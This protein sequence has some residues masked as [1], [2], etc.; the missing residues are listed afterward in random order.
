MELLNFFGALFHEARSLEEQGALRL[1]KVGKG[2]L[3]Q[4]IP[5]VRKDKIFWVDQFQTPLRKELESFYLDLIAIAKRGLFLPAKRFECHFAKYEPGDYYKRHQDQHK[6]MPSRLL[7]CVFYLNDLAPEEG[8]DLIIYDEELRPIR[9]SPEKGRMI[10]FDSQLEH[11]VRPC[12]KD[13]WS[14]TG[15]IRADLPGFNP[16]NV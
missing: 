1:A 8:G 13:R 11:E 2:D 9:I 6:F 7:T 5:E 10:I 15:W 16:M 14:L 4:R 12:S 3:K